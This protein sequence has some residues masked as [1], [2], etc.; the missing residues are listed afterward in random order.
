LTPTFGRCGPWYNIFT[1]FVEGHIKKG[2]GLSD[3]FFCFIFVLYNKQEMK[4]VIGFIVGVVITQ[5][6]LSIRG[7]GKG[8]PDA[9]GR[10]EW[11]FDDKEQ[12]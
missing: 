1:P 8:D 11:N 7:K 12:E 9:I 6:I 3:S 4:F 10:S 2:S 5:V